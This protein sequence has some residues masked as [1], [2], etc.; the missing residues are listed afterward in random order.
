MLAR[1]VGGLGAL[2]AALLGWG[3][4]AE[5]GWCGLA[6]SRWPFRLSELD[7]LRVSH[8]SDFHPRG[9]VRERKGDRRAVAWVE[10]AGPTRAG[11]RRPAHAP[12]RRAEAARADGAAGA[13]RTQ[14]SAITTSA[15]RADPRRTEPSRRTSRPCGSYA[16]SLSSPSC[17]AGRFGSSEGRD[18][19]RAARREPAAARESADL[20]ILLCHYPQVFGLTSERSADSH[21]VLAGHLH[22]GQID[23]LRRRQGAAR[24]LELA[25]YEGLVLPARLGAP[26]LAGTGNDVRPVP[27]LRTA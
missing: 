14:C 18:P 6:R 11:D 27:V 4:F 20:R 15:T 7:G 10:I 13:I 9:P 5:A 21:L 23:P 19:T 25:V 1:V 22:D 17:A 3:W 26:R 2:A 8:L 12:A 24:T 16:T